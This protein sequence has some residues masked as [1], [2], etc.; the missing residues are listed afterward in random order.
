MPKRPFFLEDAHGIELE[1]RRIGYE[2]SPDPLS[3]REFFRHARMGSHSKAKKPARPL[4]EHLQRCTVQVRYTKGGSVGKWYSHGAYIARESKDGLGFHATNDNIPVAQAMADWRR[5]GDSLFFRIIVS[6]EFGDRLDLNKQVRETV[7]Q[8]ELD[9][10]TRLEWVAVAHHNTDRPHVHVVVRGKRDNGRDLR[11]PPRYVKEGLRDRAAEAATRQLGYR[12]FEDVLE[13]QRREIHQFRFTGLDRRLTKRQDA[14]GTLTVDPGL[15]TTEFHLERR[16][17]ELERMGLVTRHGSQWQLSP[18]LESSLRAA[19]K[20]RDRVQ[21]M[22]AHG[23]MASDTNLP[24]RMLRLNDVQDVEG[25]VL[26][27]SQDEYS[28][29]NF[30]LIETVQGEMVRLPHSKEMA[31][32]RHHGNLQPGA[33]IRVRQT[34]QDQWNVVE[35]GDADLVLS[36]SR[37]LRENAGRLA[38]IVPT[39][40]DGWLGRLRGAVDHSPYTRNRHS[41]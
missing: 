37:F 32:A 13:A 5:Q 23:V 1:P 4:A 10:Q 40:Y 36:D 39:G 38:E 28:G 3:L 25:K 8:M 22:E 30:S 34:G 2:R 6:P 26:V 29:H 31:A 14:N 21:I 16:L 19:Q 15:D 20:T 12:T 7:A 41:R 18:E 33:Y 11:I 35:Y 24:F 9:L 27:H 17:I